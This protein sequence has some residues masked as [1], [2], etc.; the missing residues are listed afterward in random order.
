MSDTT[1]TIAHFLG[2][3]A[4]LRRSGFAVAPEQ[5]MAW[6]TAIELLGPGEIGDI[7][8]GSPI[9]T[10]CS[11]RIFSAPSCPDWRVSQAT[12]SRCAPPRTGQ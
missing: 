3:T 8:N 5:S 4:L 9:L 1:A 2:F 11:M 12:R 7:R 10:R 6:L